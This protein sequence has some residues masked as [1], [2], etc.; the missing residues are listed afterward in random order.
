MPTRFRTTL[1]P[2]RAEGI[3]VQLAGFGLQEGYSTGWSGTGVVVGGGDEQPL[4]AGAML[5]AAMASGVV[6]GTAMVLK[7]A[8]SGGDLDGLNARSWPCVVNGLRPYALDGFSAGCDVYLVDPVSYLAERPIWGAYRCV[9]AA[10]AVG[11][12]LSLAVGGDGKPS[13]APVLPRLPAVSVVAD[14]REALEKIPYVIA[15]GQ[16]LGDWLADFLAMLGLRAELRGYEDGRLELA[17]SDAKPRARPLEMSVV[18]SDGADAPSTDSFGPILIG[19]HSAFPGTPLRGALLDDP[20][21][22][23]AR[24]LVTYGAMGTVLTDTEVDL[25]EAWTRVHQA[26]KG[27]YAEMF[28]LTAQSRQPRL[29]PGETVRLSRRTH[30]LTDWQVSSVAHWVRAGVYDNDATLIRGDLPWHPDLPLYRPP[31]YV[32]AIVDGGNDFDFHQ[33]VP[34]DRLGR[35]KVSFPFTPTPTGQEAIDAMVAD[36]DRDGRV[37][38]DDFDDQQIEDFTEGSVRWDEERAKYDAGEYNDPYPDKEDDEL[39]VD[40]QARRQELLEKRKNVLR[41]SAF[42]RASQFDGQDA[43]RDGVASVRDS[44]VSE[45]LEE[46]LRDEDERQRLQ[47]AWEERADSPVEEGSLA[48]QYGALFGEDTDGVSDEVLAARA[49]AEEMADRWPPRIPLPVMAPMA[50]ALHGFITAHRHGDSCRVAVHGPFSAEIVGFQY[51]DDRR[52]NAELSGSVAGL[53]VE[54]NYGEAWSGLVFRRTEDMEQ[55][56]EDADDADDAGDADAEGA[57]PE[58]TAPEEQEDGGSLRPGAFDAPVSTSPQQSGGAS[59]EPGA[60][61]PGSGGASRQPGGTSG[62]PGGTSQGSGGTSREPGGASPGSGG[63]SREPGGTS[64]EPGGVS[65]PGGTSQ[66]PG[67]TSQEPGGVSQPGGTAGAGWHGR[68]AGWHIR[69]A[70]WHVR[71]ARGHGAQAEAGRVQNLIERASGG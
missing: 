71:R 29:R 52:I 42:K 60:A 21:K 56:D 53:V 43:D 10:E 15:A 65:Q 25:D 59:R 3:E 19:G 28:M 8:I 44:L 9:S 11:G 16:T 46:A 38:L 64:G 4:T 12:A 51:R 55:A 1:T 69:R 22:G 37:T 36:T 32:S 17:L 18:T 48:E 68:R 27:T 2:L 45:E 5:S 34:R 26:A 54:H 14:Y 61:S 24:P 23:S 63:T 20:A 31:V 70:G 41:Y 40:E 49:E 33:P 35:I 62:E 47:E 67:G 7:V 39:T 6:A 13:V 30:G 58:E 57:E 50:G 66:E